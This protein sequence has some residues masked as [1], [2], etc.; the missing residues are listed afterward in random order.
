MLQALL[1][2]INE[3]IIARFNGKSVGDGGDFSGSG[4]F[5][6]SGTHHGPF[7][8]QVNVNQWDRR[9]VKF[10]AIN[11]R[12]S[13]SE[14]VGRDRIYNSGGK[15]RLWVQFLVMVN[16]QEHGQ[17]VAGAIDHEFRNYLDTTNFQPSGT[18]HSVYIEG[19]RWQMRPDG[20]TLYYDYTVLM[21]YHV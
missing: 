15:Q 10:P 8:I 11:V 2:R 16:Q 17:S 21:N 7:T 6:L 19:T 3:T 13:Q 14:P 9:E 1:N 5:S 18:G 20:E 4:T 12:P